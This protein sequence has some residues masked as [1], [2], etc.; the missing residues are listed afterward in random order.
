MMLLKLTG[1]MVGN[2]TGKRD[3]FWGV[4]FSLSH[5]GFSAELP[6]NRFGEIRNR[7]NQTTP[8][9]ALLNSLTVMCCLFD[10]AT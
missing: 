6:L 1:L 7:L 8:K 4:V 5:L 9:L 10:G 2:A 3:L